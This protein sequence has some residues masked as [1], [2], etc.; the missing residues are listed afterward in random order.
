[1]WLEDRTTGLG[2]DGLYAL[3]EVGIPAATLASS[4]LL[5]QWLSAELGAAAP[6]LL[7]AKF[8]PGKREWKEISADAKAVQVA[9]VQT[10]NKKKNKNKNKN[11]APAQAALLKNGDLLAVQLKIIGA[12]PVW[13]R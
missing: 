7:L 1:M 9:H 13:V 5:R 8:L 10:S 2:A 11:R 6:S 4:G 12:P 3:R